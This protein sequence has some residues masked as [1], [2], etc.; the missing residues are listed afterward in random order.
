[1]ANE[2]SYVSNSVDGKIL[3][4][5]TAYLGEVLSINGNNARVQPLSMYKALGGKAKKA[6]PTNAVIPPNIKHKEETITYRISD[7][8][9]Q[10]TTVL[11]PDNLVVGDIVYVGICDRDITNAKNGIISEATNRHHNINDGVVLRVL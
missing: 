5:H 7:T 10:S 8:D 11:V 1:M 3:Q 4:I 9:T 6:S 2:L